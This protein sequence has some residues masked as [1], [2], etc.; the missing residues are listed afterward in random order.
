M[1]C[2]TASFELNLYQAFNHKQIYFQNSIIFILLVFRANRHNP[3][4]SLE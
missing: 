4:T 2:T 1:K 3:N